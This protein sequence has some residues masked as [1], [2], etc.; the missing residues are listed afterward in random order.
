MRAEDGLCDVDLTAADVPQTAALARAIGWNDSEADWRILFRC[1]RVFGVRDGA[2]RLIAQGTLSDFGAVATIGKMIVHA[3]LRGRGLANRLMRRALDEAARTGAR[4]VALVATALGRP[5]YLKHGFADVGELLVLTRGATEARAADARVRPLGAA[6]LPALLA[7]DREIMGCE[8][9]RMLR[10]RVAEAE[11]GFVVDGVAGLAG[12]ALALAQGDTRLV[13]PVT[14]RDAQA[15]ELLL[16]AAAAGAAG[17]VRVDV[18][19]EQAAFV[20]RL[21]DLGFV[22]SG[23][24]WEMTRGG[25]RLSWQ[26]PERFA[27]AAQAYG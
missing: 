10:A 7:L 21:G 22:E 23:R 12:F 13:G 14:A 27:L 19:V 8:R 16:T 4:D 1:A 11:A 20:A 2:G 18:P 25:R 9:E 24:R 6:D 15:A 17:T 26:R 3:E 5:V